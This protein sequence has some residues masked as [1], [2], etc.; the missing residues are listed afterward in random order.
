MTAPWGSPPDSSWLAPYLRHLTLLLQHA[1]R[2]AR[3]T[4]QTTVS[5]LLQE[6]LPK[7]QEESFP[8]LDCIDLLYDSWSRPP[9]TYL[10]PRWP[11]LETLRIYRIP[12]SFSPP[13]FE[14]LQTLCFAGCEIN[15]G[16]LCTLAV[17]APRLRLLNLEGIYLSDP[18]DQRARFACLESLI[19][20]SNQITEAMLDYFDTPALSSLTIAHATLTPNM[21]QEVQH[22]RIFP[23][24]RTLCFLNVSISGLQQ[25][26]GY[27][28]QCT[29]PRG[30]D[31]RASRLQICRIKCLTTVTPAPFLPSL[32][33][34]VVTHLAEDICYTLVDIVEHRMRG[35]CPLKE[36]KLGI[37][38]RNE[39]E[40]DD[41]LMESL[42][43]HVQVTVASYMPLRI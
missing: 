2:I 16:D 27:L 1:D 29:H 19:L 20:Q 9:D 31:L 18:F 28:L 36:L 25:Y 40:S 41:E 38:M 43:N 13:F 33:T 15:L 7:M 8:L 6:F 32:Q 5:R 26:N 35:G 3:I 10:Q 42:E 11:K 14:A 30:I 34:L 24:V 23:T 4:I 39:I 37:K 12:I 21:S 22:P 17:I